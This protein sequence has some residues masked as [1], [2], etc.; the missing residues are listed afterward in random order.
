[1][2]RSFIEILNIFLS[3]LTTTNIL[4]KYFFIKCGKFYRLNNNNFNNF[5]EIQFSI[6]SYESINHHFI[7]FISFLIMINCLVLHQTSLWLRST[8]TAIY[9]THLLH[10]CNGILVV[11]LISHAIIDYVGFYCAILQIK[12]YQLNS[13]I[14]S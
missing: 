12:H 3:F 7:D 14:N 11:T 1:M 13:K 5:N 4:H 6:N 8:L 2:Y 9:N 10:F